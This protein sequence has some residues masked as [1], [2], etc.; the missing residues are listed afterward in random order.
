MQSPAAFVLVLVHIGIC[1]VWLLA[2]CGRSGETKKRC[3]LKSSLPEPSLQE[4][5]RLIKGTPGWKTNVGMILSTGLPE[6]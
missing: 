6:A 4:V 2:D 1:H 3:C 5:D